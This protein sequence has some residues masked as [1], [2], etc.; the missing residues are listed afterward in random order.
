MCQAF[1]HRSARYVASALIA[2]LA[3]SSTRDS[4]LRVSVVLVVRF[5]GRI[6][7]MSDF[8]DAIVE[9]D[10]MDIASFSDMVLMLV[11]GIELILGI[12][13]C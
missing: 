10:F 8:V 7:L 6:F 11:R 9:T 5:D 1:I 13:G 4:L 12:A 2:F 3:D